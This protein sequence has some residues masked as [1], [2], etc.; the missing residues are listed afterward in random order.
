M[1]AEQERKGNEFV[2][3]AEK[4][5]GS[6]GG[7]F[8]GLFGFAHIYLIEIIALIKCFTYLYLLLIL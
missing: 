7:L 5:L 8:G 4:K 2:A 1:E 3:Q 6:A